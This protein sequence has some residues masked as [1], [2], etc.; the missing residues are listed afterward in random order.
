[1]ARFFPLCFPFLLCLVCIALP[2][3]AKAQVKVPEI[4]LRSELQKETLS[5]TRALIQARPENPPGNEAKVAALVAE[6][7]RAARIQTEIRTFDEESRANLLARLPGTKPELGPVLLLSH[8]DVVPADPA[9]WNSATPP[10]EAK[11][12]GGQLFGRGSLDM[13]NMVALEALTLVALKEAEVS[14]ERD[15][16]FV[17]KDLDDVVGGVLL[18]ALEKLVCL[19]DLFAAVLVLVVQDNL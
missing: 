7:L 15:V 18:A 12:Q 2:H 13:L 16:L 1:M 4:P 8:S 9:E 14:F 6:R 3:T 10:Y 5:L 17:Q 19:E 11:V